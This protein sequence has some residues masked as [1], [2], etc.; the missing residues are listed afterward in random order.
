MEKKSDTKTDSIKEESFFS[1]TN[2]IIIA[3][4]L[5]IFIIGSVFLNKGVGSEVQEI[6]SISSDGNVS[7]E[8]S[9]EHT[10][11]GD[12]ILQAEITTVYYE[13]SINLLDIVGFAADENNLKRTFDY[14]VYYNDK[15]LTNGKADG[16]V[17]PNCDEF[18]PNHVF[19]SKMN[20]KL[21]Y[22]DLMNIKFL[23]ISG[24]ES[25]VL[26]INKEVITYE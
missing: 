1:L 26:P 5:I 6:P 11:D 2:L 20:I 9:S 22:D 3:V 13:S 4:I 14:E 21:S 23:I 18:C 12:L 17:L 8:E 19:D 7:I 24:N 25:I 10:K 15:L 16:A